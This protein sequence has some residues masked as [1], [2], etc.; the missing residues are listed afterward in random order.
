MSALSLVSSKNPEQVNKTVTFTATVTSSGSPVAGADVHIIPN[1]D[2]KRT[3]P[4]DASGEANAVNMLTATGTYLVEARYAGQSASVSQVIKNK[5][6]SAE[7]AITS[8]FEV[9][10]CSFKVYPNPFDDRLK[11]EFSSPEPVHARI[12]IYDMNGRMIETVFDQPIE[13]EVMYH[14]EF[15][16]LKVVSAMYIYKVTLGKSN[17]IDKAVY[18]NRE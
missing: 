15:K 17:Y 6:K 11:F 7:I 3:V 10:T 1:G 5:V 13:G 14:A 4:T 2:R 12:D 16:P 9:K 8:D 18:K